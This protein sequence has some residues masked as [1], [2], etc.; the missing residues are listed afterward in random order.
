MGSKIKNEDELFYNLKGIVSF[1]GLN[2]KNVNLAYTACQLNSNWI[3]PSKS[4]DIK[5]GDKTIGYISVIHP[6]IKQSIAKK[7]NIA[8]LEINREMLQTIEA[9]AL[10]YKEPSKFP[11]VTLDYSF[12][13][14]NNTGYDEILNNIKAYKSDI[15]LGSSFVTLYTGKGMPE[16][17]KSMTFR[18]TIGSKEK[19]LSSEDINQFSKGIID[20]MASV[21]YLLR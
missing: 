14:D 17:K 2:L 6:K 4:V 18:F 9:P 10:K 19:T 8:V 15:L 1:I 21:G 5:Y 13:V 20:Y 3:H 16:G 12:L 7:L 11:E